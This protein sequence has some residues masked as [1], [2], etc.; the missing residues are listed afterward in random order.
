MLI[1]PIGNKHIFFA[2][3]AWS[4]HDFDVPLQRL[5]QINI[6]NKMTMKKIIFGIALLLSSSLAMV[7]QENKKACCKT[8]VFM[9]QECER[10]LYPV[11]RQQPST[12]QGGRSMGCVRCLAEWFYQS[13]PSP[14]CQSRGFLSSVSEE[15]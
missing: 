3:F 8:P 2:I 10:L 5:R 7:A 1:S 11:L 12:H 6:I 14:Q 9:R 4:S 13:P 15:S